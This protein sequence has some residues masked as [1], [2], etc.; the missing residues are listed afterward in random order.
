MIIFLVVVKSNNF[1]RI[2]NGVGVKDCFNFS[3]VIECDL[4]LELP[5]VIFLLK[6]DSVLCADA[7]T[8]GFNPFVEVSLVF[9]F[10]SG[11]TFFVVRSEH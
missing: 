8:D 7:S 5:E 2:Q 3:H 1:V 11:D 9:L 4:I 6:S 10:H